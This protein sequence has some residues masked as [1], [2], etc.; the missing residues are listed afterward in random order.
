M[1]ESEWKQAVTNRYNQSPTTTVT[2]TE[3]GTG[4]ASST[5]TA[6]ESPTS[7]RKG[8]GEEEGLSR[9]TERENKANSNQ[10]ALLSD[11]EHRYFMSLTP[12]QQADYL[13]GDVVRGK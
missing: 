12:Q 2:E 11:D 10:G 7:A 13:H 4:T 6:A 1:S 8:K 5:T 3:T 9:G